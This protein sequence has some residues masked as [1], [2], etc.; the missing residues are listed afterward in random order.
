MRAFL[1]RCKFTK[2]IA[3]HKEMGGAS[4]KYGADPHD[5]EDGQGGGG[6]SDW[7]ERYYASS[8]EQS[9]FS[10]SKQLKNSGGGGKGGGGGGDPSSAQPLG[11]QSKTIHSLANASPDAQSMFHGVSNHQE[12]SAPSFS[13]ASEQPAEEVVPVGAVAAQRRAL[14][15]SKKKKKAEE[16]AAAMTKAAAPGGR[17]AKLAMVQE[18]LRLAKLESAGFENDNNVRRSRRRRREITHAY[19]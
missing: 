11:R 10:S 19:A 16:E 9:M 4:R 12:S 17:E 3:I 13:S 2:L 18:K 8:P 5:N 1:T 14:E 6:E 15:D 7:E